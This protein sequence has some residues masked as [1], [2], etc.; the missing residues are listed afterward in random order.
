M[1]IWNLKS[2][3]F[4]F[5]NSNH[6]LWASRTTCSV[7]Q[8]S[9]VTFSVLSTP[10]FSLPNGGSE[11]LKVS[12]CGKYVLLYLYLHTSHCT[13]RAP[14]M[15]ST[16]G[17]LTDMR[18]SFSFVRA[19][20]PTPTPPRNTQPG[21][22][23]CFP[24]FLFLTAVQIKESLRK[25]SLKIVLASK[26]AA[27]KEEKEVLPVFLV[28]HPSENIWILGRTGPPQILERE[29]NISPFVFCLH[30]RCLCSFRCIHDIFTHMNQRKTVKAAAEGWLLG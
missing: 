18:Q 1:L 7:T 29:A 28:K 13:P 16:V 30:L 12:I 2:L 4:E 11:Q 25:F 23:C 8:T 20:T 21:P 3:L 9:L 22:T 6:T 15:R 26:P 14:R 17:L 5:T 19:P 27:S 24:H 10:L